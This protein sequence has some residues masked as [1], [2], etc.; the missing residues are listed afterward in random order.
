MMKEVKLSEDK[1]MVSFDV[2]SLFTNAP[3]DEALEGS[4]ALE[5]VRKRLMEDDTL[6]NQT[7]LLPS[8]TGAVSTDHLFQVPGILL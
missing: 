1:S 3:V 7:G 6:I 4:G 8:P 5:V 2:K